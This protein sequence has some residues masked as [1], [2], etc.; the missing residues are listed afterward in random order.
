MI[1]GF[2]FE[3]LSGY[4]RYHRVRAEDSVLSEA[5]FH[6]RPQSWIILWGYKVT[7]MLESSSGLISM[8]RFVCRLSLLVLL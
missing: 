8:F 1:C 3:L 2:V 7:N 6:G 4:H 5:E